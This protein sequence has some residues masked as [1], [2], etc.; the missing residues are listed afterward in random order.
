[1]PTAARRGPRS[2]PG[3]PST[4][5]AART[6]R[7]LPDA[8]GSLAWRPGIRRGHAAALGQRWR[9]AHM[10]TAATATTS[11]LGLTE[12]GNGAGF[13]LGRPI[14]WPQEPRPPLLT[15]RGY[16]TQMPNPWNAGRK[17]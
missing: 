10:P 5:I 16:E 15:R 6:R 12:A 9:V 14:Q 7:G 1:M 3:S 2:A 4:T 11:D 8:D 17:C 13:H